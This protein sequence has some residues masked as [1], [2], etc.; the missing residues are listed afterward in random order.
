MNT[1]TTG[2]ATMR[3]MTGSVASAMNRRHLFAFLCFAIFALS[4]TAALQEGDVAPDFKALA[5]VS[6]KAFDFSLQDA[7][8]KGPV[9]LY[10]FSAAFTSEC[11]IQ[12]HEFAANYDKFIAAG[13]R[14]IGVSIDSIARLN[15]FSADPESCGGKVAVAADV[16]SRIA[17]SYDLKVM[18]APPG[19]K[20]TRGTPIEHALVESVTFVI[21]PDG[22]IAAVVRGGSPSSN[23]AKTL[24]IVRKLAARQLAGSWRN[25]R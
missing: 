4:A 18:E 16:D 15:A 14:V 9:V 3:D 13:A 25:G 12:A 22:R 24:E 2:K 23:V 8:E 21:R 10:F 6:G 1:S 7:L 5:S 20:D 11:N 17:K 19:S